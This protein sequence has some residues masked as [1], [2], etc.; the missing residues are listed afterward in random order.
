MGAWNF[1]L[2]FMK[3]SLFLLFVLTIFFS[4]KQNNRFHVS[5]TVKDAAGQL[6]YFEHSGLSNTLVLDSVKLNADGEFSFKSQRPVYPDFYRLRLNDKVITFAVDSCE[7][8]IFTAKNEGFATEYVVTGSLPSIQIQT[9]RKSLILIQQKANTLNENMSSAEKT[10]KIEEIKKDIEVHKQMAEKL[11]LMNP[12]STVAYFAIYQKINDIY[13][14][15]PYVKEDKTYCAAVAT[16]YNTYMPDYER[17]KNLCSL[18]LDAIQKQRTSEKKA[19]WNE[20]LE[21]RGKG[22]IDIELKDKKNVTHKLSELEGEIVLIDFSA[23]ETKES[24]DY[25][26]ALRDLY[27][28]YHGRGFQIYQISLD[29]NKIVWEQAVENIPWICVRDENGSNTVVATTYNVSS[30]PTTFL[31]DKKGNIVGRNFSFKELDEQIH[32]LL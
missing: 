26:F 9:L 2:S 15:S 14:F 23:Y 17:T 1:F 12:R 28:K 32:R 5:G 11:I 4:C 8:I 27:N 25:T 19:E 31:M 20:I 18:V 13:L 30:I 10:A 29:D 7:N 24:V 6:I 16:S 3:K 21:K 22:Y